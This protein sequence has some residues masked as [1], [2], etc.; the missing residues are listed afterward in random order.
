M[1]SCMTGSPQLLF[2][3]WTTNAAVVVTI[4]TGRKLLKLKDGGTLS[5]IILREH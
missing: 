1:S 3:F 4:D 2:P 5:V